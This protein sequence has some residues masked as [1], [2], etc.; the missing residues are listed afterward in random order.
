MD[1]AI[2]WD[3]VP[4][5]PTIRR[6]WNVF[7]VDLEDKVDD[8]SKL[9]IE[10]DG[11]TRECMA[12]VKARGALAAFAALPAVQ[13]RTYADVSSMELSAF[14]CW[15]HAQDENGSGP[16]AGGWATCPRGPVLRSRLRPD[17]GTALGLE[18]LRRGGCCSGCITAEQRLRG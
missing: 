14:V 3:S 17:V 12:L 11:E 2:G 15:R 1:C 13:Q 6:P 9:G 10:V 18:P 5:P 4:I 8:G 7:E 16:K